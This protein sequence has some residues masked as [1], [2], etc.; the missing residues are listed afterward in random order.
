GFRI[1]SSWDGLRDPLASSK[2]LALEVINPESI[3]IG[4]YPLLLF[5]AFLALGSHSLHMSLSNSFLVLS[6]FSLNGGAH[7]AAL[8]ELITK[9]RQSVFGLPTHLFSRNFLNSS[10]FSNTGGLAMNG[11]M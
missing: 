11:P 6:I 1:T 4:A 9:K 7:I 2:R 3:L 10:P 5:F 8:S